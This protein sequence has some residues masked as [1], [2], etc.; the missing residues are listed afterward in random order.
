MGF[1]VFEVFHRLSSSQIRKT[2][3]STNE[4]SPQ[5][6]PFLINII[7]FLFSILFYNPFYFSFGKILFFNAF[8]LRKKN[9]KNKKNMIF[10]IYSRVSKTIF[11]FNSTITN[12]DKDLFLSFFLF[13]RAVGKKFLIC[14]NVAGFSK[15]RLEIFL[16]FL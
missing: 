13:F 9:W 7:I 6:I 3:S 10:N 2:T 1:A 16:P 11:I 15:M 5:P 4:H 14:E 12:G 8:M